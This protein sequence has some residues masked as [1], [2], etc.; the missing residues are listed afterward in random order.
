MNCCYDM[1]IEVTG[2]RK[3]RLSKIEEACVE[4][5]QF[6]D[7]AF[8][9]STIARKQRLRGNGE[10][11]LCGGETEDEFTDRL[12]A[13]IWKA[14]G[15]YCEVEVQA[16]CLEEPPYEQHIRDEDDYDEWRKAA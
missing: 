12:A 5:W 13:A 6:E 2:F 16:L 3:N 14:N 10:C 8:E 11:T 4:E 1:R 15:K 7:D 9:V